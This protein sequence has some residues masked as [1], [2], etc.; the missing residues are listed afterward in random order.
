MLKVVTVAVLPLVLWA[1][2]GREKPGADVA[3]ITETAMDYAY[4]WYEGD[5]ARMEPSLHPDLAKRVL[6]PDGNSG[7]L[8]I[9]H[10]SAQQLVQ[11]TRQGGGTKTPPDIRKADVSVLDVYGNAASVKLEMH[12]WV[13]Y[14]HLSKID[15]RWVI[16]NV[17]W[18]LTP[19]AKRKRGMD[20]HLN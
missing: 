11:G 6:M 13:D 2:T 14:M 12:D 19:E 4:G 10:M 15:G 3:A 1:A 9:S 16:V 18:E 20:E 7:K 17:L 5:A 8:A